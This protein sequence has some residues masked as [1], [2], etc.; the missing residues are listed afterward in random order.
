MIDVTHWVMI[1]TPEERSICYALKLNFP[2]TNNEVEYGAIIT[3][4]KFT[5]KLGIQTLQILYDFQLVVCQ[6]REIIKLRS[7]TSSLSQLGLRITYPY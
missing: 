3:R 7:T 5:K 4:L 6:V 1:V 2:A